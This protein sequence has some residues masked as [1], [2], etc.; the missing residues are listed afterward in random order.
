M[1][2]LVFDDLGMKL[3]KLHFVASKFRGPAST[4]IKA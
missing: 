4:R 2:S 1:L 3:Q